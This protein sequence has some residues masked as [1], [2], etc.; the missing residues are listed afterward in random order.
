MKSYINNSGKDNRYMLAQNHFVV[1]FFYYIIFSLFLLPCLLT[2]CSSQAKG[3]GVVLW[4][5]SDSGLV[6]GEIVKIVSE[7]VIQKAYIVSSENLGKR[8]PLEKWRLELYKTKKE[9]EQYAKEYEPYASMYAY[10]EKDGIPPVREKPENSGGVKIISKPNAYQPIKILGR[11]EEKAEI[12]E[13]T[14]YWY[15]VLIQYQGIGNDGQYQQLGGNGY[16]FGHYLEIFQTN[17][18]P[19][20]E[21]A[22]KNDTGTEE[23]PLENLLQ[24]VWRPDYFGT[25]INSGRLDLH[26]FKN[27]I[28]L[29]PDPDQ[30]K[31]VIS[32]ITD[33]YEFYYTGITNVRYNLYTFQDV[34]LRIEILSKYRI[35]VTYMA[36][37]KQV[38]SV[39]RK[40]A[41]DI[42][43]LINREIQIRN[44]LF[45]DFYLRGPVLSSSAYGTITLKEDKTIL[46]TGYERLIPSVIPKKISGSG[47]IDFPNYISS[48]L[49]DNYHGIITFFFND[50]APE[51]GIN[52]L[53]KKTENGVRLFYV[54]EEL[55][56]DRRVSKADLN[57]IVIFF[58]FSG[59]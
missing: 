58:T 24:T 4:A 34:D 16:C 19:L 30:K 1:R 33:S 25:M 20:N 43:E 40:V 36:D 18:D 13:M 5:E 7:S 28:G 27:T 49:K 42:D 2:G 39:Y 15:H 53:Y 51:K 47:W 8:V 12:N 10:S 3:Y 57:P 55:I 48:S 23:D 31:I 11:Q 21:I 50:Y 6:N 46:W 52:F 56:Q 45:E 38:T 14:D 22:E 29:F 32:T 44:A 9:A 35:S 37:G 41:T 26:M 54:R 17:G 59:A